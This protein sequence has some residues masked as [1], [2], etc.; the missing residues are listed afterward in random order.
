MHGMATHG[1][2]SLDPSPAASREDDALPTIPPSAGAVPRSHCS[3]RFPVLEVGRAAKIHRPPAKLLRGLESIIVRAQELAHYKG[4]VTSGT[5]NGISF[6]SNCHLLPLPVPW[7]WEGPGQGWRAGTPSPA[8]HGSSPW[9]RRGVRAHSPCHMEFSHSWVKLSR[10]LPKVRSDPGAAAC[11]LQHGMD[12]P[13]TF[14]PKH[15]PVISNASPS[16][17]AAGNI[18]LGLAE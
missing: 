8:I 9:P 4:T 1:H 2:S 12:D 10:A 18:P 3:C 6:C 14:H 5:W 11:V 16:P 15:L 17:R 7:V 13:D